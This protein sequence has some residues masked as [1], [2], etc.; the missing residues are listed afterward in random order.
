MKAFLSW[1]NWIIIAICVGVNLCG[2]KL[3]LGLD[4]PLWLD[5][6]GTIFAAIELG[7]LVGAFC[8]IALNLIASMGSH[9]E[10]PYM[11]V[12]AAIGISIGVLY[13]R[14]KSAH[15]RIISAGVLTGILSSIISTIINMYTYNGGTGNAW[16][17]ALMEMLS[18]DIQ[19][20]VV[21]TFL[22][23]AFVDVP[24]KVISLLAAVLA[25]RLFHTL[26]KKPSNAAPF[27]LLPLIASALIFSVPVP[28]KAADFGAE[29]AGNVYDVENGL[30]AV[31]VNAVAQTDDGYMWIGSYSGL[32]VYDGY[33]FRLATIDS[34]IKNVLALFKDSKGKL[35]IGTND[36]GV[37]C[38]DPESEQVDFYY[39][40]NGL[41][42]DAIRDITED[43]KGNIYIA[44]ISQLCMITPEGTVETFGARSFS[45]IL[46]LCSSGDSV[47]G[48]RSDGYLIIFNEEKI[49]YVLAGDFTEVAVEEEGNYIVGTSSNMT[50]RLRIK[51]GATDL[52][53][54]QYTGKLKYFNDILYSKSLKG[55]FI[56]CENGLGFVSD[57]G[58]V[59]DLSSND[60][61]SSVV[62]VFSDYQG[63]IWFGSSKQGVKKF[64]WN[65]F[66]DIF[67]RASVDGEVVNSVM[68]K[69]G[70]LYA[71]TNNGLVT[72][73]LKTYYSVPVP[74]PEFF[75]D[76]RIRNI[77]CD[78]SENVWVS[79]YGPYGLIKLRSDGTVA[80]FNSQNAKTE[81]DR[82]RFSVELSDG[83]IVAASNTGLTF[84]KGEKVVKTLGEN[85]GISTQVLSLVEREDGTLYAGTDGGGIL[86]LKND[87]I[88]RT[89][90]TAEGL[91]TLVVM[92]I[93]PCTG[94]Y[95]Y[96][97][98]NAI[99]YDNDKEIRRLENFPY[100]NNYDVFISEEGKVW[101]FSS[102]GIYVLDEQDLLNDTQYSF[103][104]L[105]RSRG[106]NTAITANSNYVLNG[107]RLYISCTDGVRRVS[108]KNYDSFNNEFKIGLSEI[109]AGDQKIK[110][111]DGVY[112]I[113]A[114]SG[115]IQ[116]DVAVMNYSLSNP[117][118]HIFLE[119][120]EDQGITCYQKNMQP[121]SFT[122]LPY[123]DYKLHVQVLDTAGIDVVRDEVFP[124]RKE[125]Q[126]FERGYFRVYLYLVCFL[127]ILYLG[128]AIGDILHNMNNVQRL[129]QEA[130]KDHLTGLLNKRGAED[131]MNEACRNNS[132][133]LAVLDL[134]SFKP[135]NDIF[136]HD[137]GDRLL[138]ALAD[139]MRRTAGSDDVL[140]R[141]GGDEFVAFYKYATGSDIKEKTRIL[142]EELIEV[143]K[144]ILGEDMNIPLGVSIGAVAVTEGNEE[145]YEEL[146]KKADKA[147]Y[148]V[149][150]SGKHDYVIYEE[151]LFRSE[152]NSDRANISGIAEIRAI[153]GE[154][155]KSSKPYRVEDG[156]L[157]EIYRLLVRLGDSAV[158]NSVMIHFIVTGEKGK[159]VPHD[160][161][162]IFLEV[163]DDS[164]RSTDV[165]GY[166]NHSTAIV[167]L[168]NTDP[169]FAVVTIER[170]ENKWKEHPRTQGYSV[171]YEKEML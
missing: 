164:L 79:T 61:D 118:I 71:G 121:L 72:I 137:N 152:E 96:V 47:A 43:S 68:V 108:I 140:C 55:Y 163:L 36:S 49:T 57:K 136:G 106:L 141:V 39:T 113:P 17:D 142:N 95:L 133:I 10:M 122:N 1:K 105:N 138:M 40:G 119:G 87:E 11:L 123:G 76:V 73:D 127:F 158:M 24:D 74:H 25:S 86:V 9:Q 22:G 67:S 77:M 162:D 109:M 168:T 111:V 114:V 107:E 15:F 12:S 157:R 7:P 4:L 52:M 110:P 132:G 20:P 94:G 35:W 97:T 33:K 124:V 32:Y 78:S 151:S 112:T 130:T 70:L 153:I 66:E 62:S 45:G 167:I 56:A 69:K 139:L 144:H 19:L 125:S 8:G 82:F 147:L 117:M 30:E 21:N 42:S 14:Q 116:F 5:S 31:E 149:K 148:I 83:R 166:D 53:T 48:I 169:D 126:L 88:V 29:Y 50:A 102:G 38:Y 58:T 16:G 146:F 18:R 41:S 59:T 6:A 65:P 156:R 159:I 51:D 64:S 92:K 135:V 26:E 44:T 27:I 115:R 103:M 120:A 85:E 23:Q 143:A 99:Y 60:F 81:G 37:A 28:V 128:W 2:R 165:Y 89:I 161:M 91:R 34:R 129:Q 90:G 3:A 131:T 134:D 171:A 98:S 150:N 46:K 93:V 170:I 154:R 101:V 75:K 104:L 100:S 80:S 54:K 84:I 160:I 13:P 63:N 155:N 145:S